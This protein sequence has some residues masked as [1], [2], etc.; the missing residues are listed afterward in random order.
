MQLLINLKRISSHNRLAVN[1]QYQLSNCLDCIFEQAAVELI[2]NHSEHQKVN[3]KKFPFT[4]SELTFDQLYACKD[5]FFMHHQGESATLEVRIWDGISIRDYLIDLFQDQRIS[6]SFGNEVVEY[7]VTS[8]NTIRP[9]KF[10]AEMNYSAITPLFLT[11]QV[12][13][14]GMDIISPGDAAYSE[15]FKTNLLK[16]FTIQF[17]ELKGLK[18]LKNCC[19]EMDFVP[20]SQAIEQERVFNMYDLDLIHLTG[21]KFDFKLKASPILQEFGYYAGFGAQSSLGFGCVK[22]V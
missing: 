11:K 10:K 20:T 18:D 4:F 7:H 3:Q 9:P 5:Q 13:N 14:I 2:S 15:V 21:F 19:P 12:E 1:Y 22:A 16:R 17:P 6:F 8:V